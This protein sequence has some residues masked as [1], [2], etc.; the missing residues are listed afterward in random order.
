MKAAVKASELLAAAKIAD[1][2]GYRAALQAVYIENN[3]ECYTITATDSYKLVHFENAHGF[4]ETENQ[5]AV[6]I[7]A[8]FIKANIKASDD[9][10]L[11]EAD[12]NQI[13][14]SIYKK[15]LVH[16]ADIMTQPVEATYPN[17]KQLFREAEKDAPNCQAFSAAYMEELCGAIVKAYG[18]TAHFKITFTGQNRAAM[19]EAHDETNGGFCKAIIMPVKL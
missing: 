7:S 17:Y 10:V 6:L 2:K 13:K 9:K 16:R 19:I 12:E 3:G 15:K 5:G 1:K 18:N 4:G 8:E 11:I 14:L